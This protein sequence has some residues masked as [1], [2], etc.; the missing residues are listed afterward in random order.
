MNA[1]MENMLERVEDNLL[2]AARAAI[3]NWE[4]FPWHRDRHG[5]IQTWKNGSSQALA[6]DVL[7]TIK[8]SGERDRVLGGLAQKCGL[9]PE[10]PW[11][12]KLEWTD[13][14]N[15][16][17][18]PRPTQLDAIAF[19]HGAILV[20]E[21]KFTEG[22]GRCTQP[23]RIGEGE[24]GGLRQCNGDYMLQ[25]NLVNKKEAR[26]ALTGKRVN[27]W[28]RIPRIF[29]LDA[30]QDHSPCPFRGDAYQ[31]MRNV[32]LADALAFAP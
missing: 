22:G 27:Y 7:G 29:G 4:A 16:L 3:E 17:Q 24:H 6:I 31:W 26:C 30:E 28:E 12:V 15:L 2:P 13:P 23:D 14:D 20:F 8:I 10:G 9:P 25:V 5:N 1:P 19:G 18:E 11:A 32:V 21:C